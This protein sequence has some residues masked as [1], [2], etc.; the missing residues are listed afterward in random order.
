[1]G[2]LNNYWPVL[3]VSTSLL[4][5]RRAWTRWSNLSEVTFG[6]GRSCCGY[7]YRAYTRNLERRKK[8]EGNERYG[9]GQGWKR[10][11]K[12]CRHFQLDN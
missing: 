7:P 2:M 9:I 6:A 10:R 5:G 4:G 3:A 8:Q 1:M 11:G 12:G